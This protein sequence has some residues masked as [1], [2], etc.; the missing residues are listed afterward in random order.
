L[1]KF[2][3]V[4]SFACLGPAVGI[5]KKSKE[6]KRKEKKRKEKKCGETFSPKS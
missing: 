1:T 2:E 3:G 6:K 4:D 5:E